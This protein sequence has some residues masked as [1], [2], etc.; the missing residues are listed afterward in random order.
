MQQQKSDCNG[1]EH[2]VTRMRLI[3][4]WSAWDFNVCVCLSLTFSQ[5]TCE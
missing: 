3:E 5:L 4:H 1:Q 2:I